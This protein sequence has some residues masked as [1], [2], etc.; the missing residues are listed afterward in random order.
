MKKEK[1][2]TEKP[3]KKGISLEVKIPYTDE[4]GDRKFHSKTFNT[5]KYPTNGDAMKAAKKYRDRFL[6]EIEISIPSPR[7]KATVQDCYQLTKELFSFS[8]ETQRKHDIRFGYLKKYHDKPIE[9]VT[10][11]DVQM[12]LNALTHKS[13]DVIK[14]VLALWKQIFKAAMM[15]DY[16][17]RD[18]T[19]KVVLPKS[20]KISVPKPVEMTC[21]LDDVVKAIL[22][23]GQNPFNST[24]IAY[25]MITISYLGLRPSEAYALTKED[26]NFERRTVLVNK[27][28]GST[29]KKI[30]TVKTTKNINSVRLLP[31]P[32]ELVPYLE[33]LMEYQ[34]SEYL[35][36]TST[37]E[38]ITSRKYAD[39]IHNA[40]VKANITF[41]PYMLRH[42][43]STRLITSNTDVRT[44]QEL[45]GH[46]NISMTIDYARSS[47]ELKRNAI[48]KISPGNFFSQNFEQHLPEYSGKYQPLGI[49]KAP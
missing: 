36:A 23:Y 20:E 27:A 9:R 21:G 43:F 26:I 18:P 15:N 34:P 4:Y 32:D 24:V 3:G 30:A 16:V 35:F 13:Q 6:T 28:I 19:V 42:E 7:K 22:N 10:A 45:M 11:V 40:M 12:S 2:I 25:A 38:F 14:S 41:R 5:S 31:L 49:E 17:Y 37:G 48:S 33:Y 47:E 1:F 44:V 29:K 8:L 46:K 39:F